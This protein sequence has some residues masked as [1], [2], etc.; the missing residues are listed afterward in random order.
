M[1]AAKDA[2]RRDLLDLL[3][4][5]AESLVELEEGKFGL[6]LAHARRMHELVADGV[7][8]VRGAIASAGGPGGGDGRGE[9]DERA[10]VLP[11]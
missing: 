1:D 6:V 3:Q 8:H 7:A 9:R 2:A 5:A 4:V 10:E 11:D